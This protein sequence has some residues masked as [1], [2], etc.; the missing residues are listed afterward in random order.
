[1]YI[2]YFED[3]KNHRDFGKIVYYMQLL[4]DKKRTSTRF[5]LCLNIHLLPFF[6]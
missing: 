5:S 6:I 4:S 1:M 2:V 3:K